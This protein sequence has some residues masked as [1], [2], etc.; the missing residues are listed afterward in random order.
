MVMDINSEGQFDVIILRHVV[1]HMLDPVKI[2]LKK[3]CPQ[4]GNIAVKSSK[5][6]LAIT[7]LNCWVDAYYYCKDYLPPY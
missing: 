7:P 3:L 2:N 4:K 1:E 5:E 6:L